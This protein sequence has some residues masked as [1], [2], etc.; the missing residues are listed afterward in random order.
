MFEIEVHSNALKHGLTKEEVVF[1]W[2][3]FVRRQHRELPNGDQIIAVGFDMH[4]NSIELIAVSK[5]F[6][7][8]IY[9]A[10]TPPTEKILKE[11]GIARR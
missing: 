1:A 5:S 6:G 9:H 7:V 10:M 4:G 11:L 3:N 8:L 2:E